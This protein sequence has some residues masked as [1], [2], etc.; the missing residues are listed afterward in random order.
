MLRE[1]KKHTIRLD[2]DVIIRNNKIFRSDILENSLRKRAADIS[3]REKVLGK[4]N[5]LY[6]LVSKPQ[7]IGRRVSQKHAAT[8]TVFIENREA[9]KSLSPT[10]KRTLLVLI[11]GT[12]QHAKQGELLAIAL[13]GVIRTTAI[14]F[15]EQGVTRFGAILNPK[16]LKRVNSLAVYQVEKDSLGKRLD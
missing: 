8:P 6:H 11:T 13:N 1:T 10:K 14:T 12:V 2:I 9:L 7:L 15:N 16:F 3:Y 4:E 5:S